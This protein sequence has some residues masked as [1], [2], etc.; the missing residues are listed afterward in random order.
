M[1]GPQMRTRFETGDGF[2]AALGQSGGST[3][4]ALKAYGIDESQYAGRNQGRYGRPGPRRR[5]QRFPVRR[6]QRDPAAGGGGAAIGSVLGVA[7]GS[8]SRRRG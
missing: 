3:P 6:C 1:S 4:K 5:G 2:I 8:L 7:T